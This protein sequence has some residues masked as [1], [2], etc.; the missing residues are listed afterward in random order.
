MKRRK[1]IKLGLTLAGIGAAAK[2]AQA[3]VPQRG[4]VFPNTFRPSIVTNPS[5]PVTP[6]TVPLFVMPIAQPVTQAVL[7]AQG[8]PIDPL[9]HQRY[10][11]FL[12]QK[13]YVQRISEFTWIYHTDPPYGGGSY[14]WGFNGITPGETFHAYYHEPH[15]VRRINELPGVGSA[16][17]NWALPSVAIHRHNGHQ[18]SESDGI[19]Q[20]FFDPGQFWD[21]HYP[22]YPAGGDPREIMSTLWYHDHRLDFTATN[23]Y[24]GLSGFH[25]H[26]DDFDSNN[27]NDQRKGASRLPSGQYDV[28]LI[29]HDVQFDQFGQVIFDFKNPAATLGNPKDFNLNSRNVQDGAMGTDSIET[30]RFQEQWTNS[31]SPRHTT[32]GMIGDRYTVNRII[33]P[34]FR[35]E[36]RKYRFRILNGG[37]SRLYNLF[38]KA[39]S[40]TG[41][42]PTAGERFIV[43][44][45]DGN[46]LP[47]PLVQDNIEIWVAQRHDV[48]IDFSNFAAGES[49][50]LVNRLAMR[51]DG[52][53][54]NGRDL[55]PGDQI[56][57]FDVVDRTQPDPSRIPDSLRGLPK[58]NLREVRRERTFVF[59]YD[60]GLFTVNGRLMDPNR[61]DAKIEQGSAEI[62]TLRNEGNT[63]V[64]PIHSHF[65]EFQ[66][67]EVNGKPVPKN[68][69]LH[70]RKDVVSLGPNM[71]V[72][73]FSRWRDFLGMYVMHCHNVLHEDH[74][75]M[76]RWDIVPPGQGD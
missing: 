51:E 72:K 63:W 6:F 24:A 49:V 73:F 13:F 30:W 18:A 11:E 15:L 43:I 60:N 32:F 20:D 48:I 42:T 33:Q 74:A 12:P 22:M 7:E 55:D 64:H 66:I 16:K 71:E 8:G 44:S 76:I 56:M 10:N 61:V 68:D 27:E 9:A 25:L 34:Y 26:F 47:E 1:A 67:L 37:P 75:M 14:A 5:P 4:L 62:W 39:A 29:L 45:N 40:S 69:V 2:T 23:V 36:R 3:K 31:I 38:L 17:V 57:R 46:L 58:I 50:Y 19:P 65:E 28:P 70:S 35:V 54:P 53:G 41:D 59:D 21:Y 52:A